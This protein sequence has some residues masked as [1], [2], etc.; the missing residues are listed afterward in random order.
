MTSHPIPSIAS[1]VKQADSS[2]RIVSV[3]GHKCYASDTMGTPSADYILCSLIYHDRWV[4]A[5]VPPHIPPPG[6]IN[7]HA[8][9]VPIPNPNSGFAPAVQQWSMGAED[10]WTMNYAEWAFK[11]VHPR[12]LMMNLAE[13]DVLGHF[14][15]NMKPIRFLMKQFDSLLGGLMTDYRRAGILSRT[16]FVITADHGMT[17]IHKYLPFSVINQAIYAAHATKVYVEHD[18]AAAIGIAQLNKS[19]A[20]AANIMRL[21]GSMIDATYYKVRHNG[22]WIYRAAA[23]QPSLSS[24][25]RSAYL[26]L[27][28]TM[29]SDTSADVWAVYAPHISSRYFKAHGYAWLQGHLGPQWGDQH[30][31]LVIS[32]PGVKHGAR[33]NYPARLIDIAPTVENLLGV[34]SG[35]VDG[36]VLEDALARPHRG[37]LRSQAQRGAAIMPMVRALESR[38]A[39][40]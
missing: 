36:G 27:A 6:P 22:K 15:S 5:A 7:N 35:G 28:D 37:A 2:A 23:V 34:K 19:R 24:A 38:W 1:R 29:A 12:V 8:W 40:G 10:G 31:P 32:G 33:S 39:T 16:D 30:I 11:K 3:A 17:R 14:A 25:V 21:G 13:T 18:T 9:D 4:A 26:K 20:V